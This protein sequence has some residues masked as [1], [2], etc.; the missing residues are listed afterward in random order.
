MKEEAV[1][2]TS[3]GISTGFG[4]NN[5]YTC[6]VFTMARKLLMYSDILL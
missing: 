4:F 6:T 1:A 3:C 5:Q 2:F